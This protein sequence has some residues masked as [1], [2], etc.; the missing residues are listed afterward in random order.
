[1][2]TQ[3]TKSKIYAAF[4]ITLFIMPILLSCSSEENKLK[5][6]VRNLKTSILQ[7][8][9]KKEPPPL[10][11]KMPEPISYTSQKGRSPF[12]PET[13]ELTN[14]LASPL[15]I[16]PVSMLKFVG[17]VLEN[18]KESAYVIAPDTKLYQI[19]EGD[20]V[21]IRNGIVKTIT[22]DQVVILEKNP[23]VTDKGATQIVTLQLKE[24]SQ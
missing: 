1:M 4:C 8:Y 14:K 9:G 10:D 23:E 12:N 16:Y 2:Q 18:G 6:Y 11:L 15:L 13:T 5:N 20:K 21:G 24:E 19:R 22:Y 3:K 7:S 17:T